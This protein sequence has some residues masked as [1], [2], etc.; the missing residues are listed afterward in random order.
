MI[1]TYIDLQLFGQEKK[2]PATPRKRRMAREKGQIAQ[3]QDLSSAVGL[4]GGILALKYAFGPLAKLV[5]ERSLQI[6]QASAPRDASI[7]WAVTVLRNAFGLALLAAAPVVLAVLLGGSILSAF[8]VGASVKLNL[9][10]PEFNKINPLQGVKKL[11]SLK[12]M[13]DGA[14]SMLK[15]FAVAIC[16]WMTLKT[17]LPEISSL[18]IRQLPE[19]LVFLGNTASRLALNCGIVLLVLGGLDYAYQWWE[20]ER[21]LMMTDQE[22]RDELRDTE[23]KPEVKRA[24]RAKQRMFAQRRMMQALPT[25]DAVIVNPEHYAVAIKYDP[26]VNH[27]PMV[28]AKGLDDLALRIRKVAMDNGVQ[29][30]SDPPLARGL[31]RAV[32]I[33]EFVPED[34]Y[35]A[36]AE[37][38]A[39]VYRVTGKTPGKGP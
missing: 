27:A 5:A 38:L 21:S 10:T 22:L 9:L 29:I 32:D 37:V 3:S 2:E 4:L 13:V 18:L 11:F 23:A 1:C 39:Y 35:R 19:S 15:M 36:V 24:I 17:V 33:G 8:Q 28:V 31:Y 6:W 12:A 25:A 16:L 7:S 34:F 30:V 14:K 26:E 20:L